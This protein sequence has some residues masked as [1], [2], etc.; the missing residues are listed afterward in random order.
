MHA[1]GWI[2]LYG[3]LEAGE[4]PPPTL[5][6]ECR[7]NRNFV[8]ET[9]LD[10]YALEG[11]PDV[12]QKLIDLGFAVDRT[13]HPD[14]VPIL[15]AALIGRWDNVRVLRRA[16]ACTRGVTPCGFTYRG[17]VTEAGDAVPPDLRGDAYSLDDLLDFD[18][19][20][21]QPVISVRLSHP[22]LTPAVFAQWMAERPDLR[23][24]H[25]DVE[26]HCFWMR[27]PGELDVAV[28]SSAMRQLLHHGAQAIGAKIEWRF[29]VP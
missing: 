6:M 18:G 17:L 29:K 15:R 2:E 26:A 24:T 23:L 12:L 13:G 10:W 11:S 3:M 25:H 14:H 19:P 22:Q 16:G 1:P 20:E 8:G 28:P 27:G 9:M 4:T 5:V 7:H 21:D